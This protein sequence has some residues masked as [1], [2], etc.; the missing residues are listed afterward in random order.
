[1]G[2]CTTKHSH[3]GMKTNA[4][5][6]TFVVNHKNTDNSNF[7]N[8]KIRY[9]IFCKKDSHT[10]VLHLELNKFRNMRISQISYFLPAMLST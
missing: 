4:L 5:R 10:P 1:M 3:E 7:L 2:S 6:P 8:P 9:K